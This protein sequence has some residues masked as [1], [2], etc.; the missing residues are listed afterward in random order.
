MLNENV[1]IA[2][3]LPLSGVNVSH[4]TTMYQ[5]LDVTQR[6]VDQQPRITLHQFPS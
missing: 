5:D 3:E 4:Q 2:S 1:K 6:A